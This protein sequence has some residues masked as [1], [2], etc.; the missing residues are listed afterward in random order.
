MFD[1]RSASATREFK[2]YTNNSLKY[3]LDCVSEPETMR[4]CYKAIGRAGGKYTA[5]EPFTQFLHTRPTVQPDWVLG[6]T[7]LGKPIGWSPPFEWQAN[8]K[9]REFTLD[10]FKT[11]QN[12]LDE[13]TL[14][15]Y[16]VR[17]LTGEFEAAL[18]G[19]DLLQEKKVSGQRLVCR[20]S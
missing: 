10:W 3:I 8:P 17:I 14:R 6:P 5:L 13:G 20:I 11:V 7:L 15:I 1:Y 16:P 2:T 12:L 9:M 18:G 19:L 4:F